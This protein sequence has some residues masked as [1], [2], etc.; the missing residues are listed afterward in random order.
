MIKKKRFKERNIIRKR[1][2]SLESCAIK[3]EQG[4]N[5]TKIKQQQKR[6]N[7]KKSGLARLLLF[8]NYKCQT[9]YNFYIQRCHLDLK[10]SKSRQ[11][12]G[13]KKHLVEVM[14]WAK[15]KNY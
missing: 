2:L 6:E 8:I 9:C 5:I 7:D 10:S 3:W 13:K 4:R 14:T 12:V 11:M 15:F 1:F